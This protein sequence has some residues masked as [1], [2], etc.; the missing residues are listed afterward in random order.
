MTKLICLDCPFGFVLFA[1][2]PG[3]EQKESWLNL[4]SKCKKC[5]KL[6][7]LRDLL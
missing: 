4:Q 3:D 7:R 2:Y 5:G 1:D 6:W